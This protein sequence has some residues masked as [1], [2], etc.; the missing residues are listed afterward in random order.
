MTQREYDMLLKEIRCLK[1]E[2]SDLKYVVS[3]Q[4]GVLQDLTDKTLVV[5]DV[6]DEITKLK[7]DVQ[8]LKDEKE[9]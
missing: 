3:K 2:V 5:S 6:G 9:M 4:N 1:Q 7:T 8:A